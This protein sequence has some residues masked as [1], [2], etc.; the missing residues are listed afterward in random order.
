ARKIVYSII[1]VALGMVVVLA[2]SNYM[3]AKRQ[4]LSGVDREIG[5]LAGQAAGNLAAFFGQRRDDALMLAESPVLHDY[6]KYLDYDLQEEAE[7]Y[8][9]QLGEYYSQFASKK[10]VY[11]RVAYCEASGREVAAGMPRGPAGLRARCGPWSRSVPP[12]G[13]V[14]DTG[15][16]ASGGRPM[17]Y[18]V[19]VY[20]DQG[21]ARGSIALSCDPANVRSLL[22]QVRIGEKGRALLADAQGREL[23]ASRPAFPDAVYGEAAVPGSGLR[24]RL[25]AEPK[26][27]LAPLRAV[28]RWTVLAAL[29][30]V[31]LILLWIGY[32]A[33]KAT[34]PI[35]D[36]AEGTRKI[37]AGDLDFRFDPPAI[38]EL[39]VLGDAF[40]DMARSLKE[41]KA[42]LEARIRQLTAL[43]RMDG[44]VMQRQDEETILRTCL[45][46]AAMGLS[47]DRTGLY[48][49][50]AGKKEIVGRFLHRMEA[51]GFTERT[52]R[53]RRIPLGEDD[54]LNEVVRTRAAALVKEPA[55]DR[56]LNPGYL[57]E[58]KTREFLLAPVCGKDRVFGV[59]AADNYYGG[60]PLEEADKDGLM[61]FANALGL[62][63]ENATLFRDLAGSEARY[64]TV[65]SNSPEAVLGLSREQW[66]TTW[67]GGGE[68]IFGYGAGEVMGK[69]LT[70]L[71]PESAQ[72]ECQ[73]MLHEVM[74][75]GSVRDFPMTG[76]A[77]GGAPLELSV[78][79]GGAHP[80]FW[81][82]KE[83]TVVIRDVTEARKL[84][85]Q[86]IRS[87]KLS[88]VGQ[89]ISGIA[90]ELNN[91]LQ[92]VVGY[93][94][95]L[96]DDEM[97]ASTRQEMR[98][99]VQNAMRCRKIIENLL[100]FVRQATTEKRP[101]SV[102]K[103][104]RASLS[105]L[106]YRL[107]KADSVRVEA[108]LPKTLPK[109][110]ADLQQLEQVLV[111]LIANACDAMSEQTGPKGL[112]IRARAR[113]S[114][115]RVSVSDTGP[116]I[117]PEHRAH[118]LEP[119]FSTKPEGRGT[120]LGLTIC[121]QIL[122]EHGGRLGLEE[123]A[124]GGST[125]WLELPKASAAGAGVRKKVA[126]PGRVRGK[127]ILVVDD[128]PAVLS[129]IE[130]VLRMEGHQVKGASS[131]KQAFSK[132]GA[133][134]LD[135]V[136]ADIRLSDGDGLRLHEDWA[137]HTRQP[138]PEF[139][140]LTGDVLNLD[141]ER[142]LAARGLALLHK[143]A[144]ADELRN[145]VRG[146]LRPGKERRPRPAKRAARKI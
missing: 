4:I 68:R 39:R 105:L 111:N 146:L 100:L 2:V 64:R 44:T 36:M 18:Q 87:E 5:I 31:T 126:V 77:K 20:D 122:E 103:A 83:W 46:A 59:F 25:E 29:G 123:R 27:F 33:R 15:V 34:R 51:M 91:P 70:A 117:A 142:G 23:L 106:E 41:R 116:G 109:V 112:R 88:A 128:E 110:R 9:K 102:A 93:A 82:N 104:V 95:L 89:L 71:F 67:S 134:R 135:L 127:A 58:T 130:K 10:G 114:M 132:A 11:S 47:F 98:H 12:A 19:G 3:A 101:V 121:R 62:A 26:E 56:R 76:R 61:L 131:L 73:R 32:L 7:A 120:G 81:M 52:F 139:L 86:L 124:G 22:D 75:K 97:S 42:Q 16:P 54:I 94:Q 108:R 8:R 90:H 48:W 43:R 37:A 49:V 144:D 66:I 69:P 60:R 129:F 38:R 50:D 55:L 80:D 72:K 40:N 96:S 136:V 13:K 141:L 35:A 107:K 30:A 6:L 137:S 99:I 63:L 45:R 65:L 140:F 17:R 21:R 113:G 138:R 85:R 14:L 92:A 74:E 24:V 133:A 84:E 79:W 119:F 115:V 1:P 28:Q 53:K 143:P 145:A 78:S 118:I 125:F 57:T